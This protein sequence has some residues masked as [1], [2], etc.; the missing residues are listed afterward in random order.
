MTA[1][2][3]NASGRNG[4]LVD[5]RRAG[6]RR[7]PPRRRA[8]PR[9]STR[10]RGFAPSTCPA[11]ASTRRRRAPPA[12]SRRRWRRAARSLRFPPRGRHPSRVLG[13]PVERDRG[14]QR[15]PAA[16]RVV[17]SG[18]AVGCRGIRVELRAP[19]SLVRRLRPRSAAPSGR[20]TAQHGEHERADEEADRGA[21]DAAPLE[22]VLE[23]L[24]VNAVIRAPAANDRSMARSRFGRS[25]R[26]PMSEPMTRAPEA[27]MPKISDCHGHAAS[28]ESMDPR[29]E[30]VASQ[31]PGVFRR[32][33]E[34][35]SARSSPRC[36]SVPIAVRRSK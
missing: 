36:R 2:A 7:A 30:G 12:G 32:P 27:T 3:A 6:R 10:A 22:G 35:C 28:I 19:L 4:L 8:A 33:V 18:R 1:P 5:L 9:R 15:E 31:P 20:G 24:E 26:T 23:E 25:K 11:C 34:T 13:H 21:P 17:A 14:Q 29:R 16:P